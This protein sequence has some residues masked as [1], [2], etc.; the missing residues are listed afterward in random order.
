VRLFN[1]IILGAAGISMATAGQIEIGPSGSN[2]VNGGNTTNTAGLTTA[3]ITSGDL[4]GSGSTAWKDTSVTYNNNLF[5]NDTITSSSLNGVT[6]SLGNGGVSTTPTAANGFQQ[7]TDTA[8]PNGAVTFAMDTDSGANYW[9]SPSGT[10]ATITI[11]VG[12]MSVTDAYILLNDYYGPSGAQDAQ[13]TFNFSSGP[14]DVVQL[15]NGNQID[16]VHNCSG[17]APSGNPCPTTSP[18]PFNGSVTSSGTDIA[19]SGHYVEGSNSTP[20]SLTQ[21]TAQL[22]DITFNLSAYTG[23]TLE[24]I[25]ITDNH[26]VSGSSR[27]ALSAITLQTGASTPT[28]E[29]STLVLLFAGLGLMGF[30]GRRKKVRL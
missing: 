22:D 8:N 7:F 17:P 30:L 20:Y 12:V 13:V 19:W 27:L 24:S 11:P 16:S 28:P 29:P 25:V 1:L 2:V 23:L 14:A 10:N 18:A 9:A 21:G 6:G 26:D 5:T 3:L 4:S 15:N